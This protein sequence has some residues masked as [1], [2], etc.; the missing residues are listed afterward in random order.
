MMDISFI[1]QGNIYK[2]KRLGRID[3]VF[4]WKTLANG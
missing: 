3:D 1:F 4:A 2:K